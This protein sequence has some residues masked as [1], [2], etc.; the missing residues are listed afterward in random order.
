MQQIPLTAIPQRL[1]RMPMLQD[2]GQTV[3]TVLTQEPPVV[4]VVPED[5]HRMALRRKVQEDET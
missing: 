4:L 3:S 5:L 2:P 1:L